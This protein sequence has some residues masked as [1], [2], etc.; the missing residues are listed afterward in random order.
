MSNL[1]QRVARR[2]CLTVIDK[3][4]TL[5]KRFELAGQSVTQLEASGVTVSAIL[6]IGNPSA[7]LALTDFE[8]VDVLPGSSDIA[9]DGSSPRGS[10]RSATLTTVTGLPSGVTVQ[11]KHSDQSVPQYLCGC[12]RGWHAGG[13]ACRLYGTQLAD[14]AVGL[15]HHPLAAICRSGTQCGPKSRYSGSELSVVAGC[16]CR[17]G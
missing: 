5:A 15:Q 14:D 16:R 11:Y 3:E 2:E 4:M 8:L 17:C 1:L 13:L 9:N 10:T 7:T 12:Q 6:T